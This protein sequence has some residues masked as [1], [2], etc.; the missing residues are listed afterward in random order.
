MNLKAI[1]WKEDKYYVAQCI[2]VEVS[3][4]GKS[5]LEAMQNLD[6]AMNCILKMR[7]LLN[8]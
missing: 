3:S 6:E 5:K 2:N 1:I 7:Q 4:F 8:Q